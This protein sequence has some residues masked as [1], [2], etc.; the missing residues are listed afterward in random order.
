MRRVPDPGAPSVCASVQVEVE[1]RFAVVGDGALVAVERCLHFGQRL[2]IVD[3]RGLHGWL[4]SSSG[5]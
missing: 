1:M 3:L 2:G 5:S 4:C